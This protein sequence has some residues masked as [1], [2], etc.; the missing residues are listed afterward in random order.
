MLQTLSVLS[1]IIY[2]IESDKTFVPRTWFL[3]LLFFDQVSIKSIAFLFW[4][5]WDIEQN[6]TG[7]PFSPQRSWGLI[8][9]KFKHLELSVLSQI[10]GFSFRSV[11]QYLFP[12]S[13]LF[14]IMKYLVMSLPR[15]GLNKSVYIYKFR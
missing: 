14:M 6:G 5:H 1:Q 2:H 12:S 15:G 8:I 10:L 7:E 9:T 4:L 11:N 13:L 3:L